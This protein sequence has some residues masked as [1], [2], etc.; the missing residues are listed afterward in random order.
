MKVKICY[1]IEVDKERREAIKY[2]YTGEI[3][4]PASR[5]DII[6][7]F[8]SYGELVLDDIDYSYIRAKKKGKED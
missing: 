7:F 8:R 6:F 5:E 3:G 2:H 4:K 1:T